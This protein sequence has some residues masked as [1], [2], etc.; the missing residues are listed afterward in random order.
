[1][2]CVVHKRLVNTLLVSGP[3]HLLTDYRGPGPCLVAARSQ[4]GSSETLPCWHVTVYTCTSASIMQS[5][6]ERGVCTLTVKGSV[7]I[8]NSKELTFQFYMY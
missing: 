3:V 5:H 4:D 6:N 8:S 7:K 2:S 1:M